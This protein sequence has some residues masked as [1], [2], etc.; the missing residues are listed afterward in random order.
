MYK[1]IKEAIKEFIDRDYNNSRWILIMTDTV[2]LQTG[3]VKLEETKELVRAH[4]INLIVFW[5]GEQV[6]P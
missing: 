3:R 2:G 1:G 6:S 4:R 5:Y